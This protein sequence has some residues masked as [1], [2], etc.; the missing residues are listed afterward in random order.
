MFFNCK[1]LINQTIK[2]SIIVTGLV[3]I[4]VFFNKCVCDISS[5]FINDESFI[6]KDSFDMFNIIFC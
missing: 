4:S 3:P 6:L 1:V 5:V 2:N